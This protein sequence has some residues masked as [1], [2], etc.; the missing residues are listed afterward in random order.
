MREL[1]FSRIWLRINAH[2]DSEKEDV[3]AEYKG[4]TRE[5]LEQCI[6]S[7]QRDGHSLTMQREPQ[8]FTMTSPEG[9]RSSVKIAARFVPINITLEPRESANS[10]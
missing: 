2:D 8:E 10:E 6:V 3:V 9:Q 1:D 7:V 4:D 5:F